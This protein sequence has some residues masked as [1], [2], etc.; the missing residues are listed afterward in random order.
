MIRNFVI[1]PLLL[2]IK[3]SLS[4]L[5][6]DNCEILDLTHDYSSNTK[7]WGMKESFKLETVFKG[8]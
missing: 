7:Y 5:L 2:L 3:L 4:F 8:Y 6:L 1:F